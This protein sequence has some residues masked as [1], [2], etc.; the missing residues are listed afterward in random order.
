MMN[1]TTFAPA[2]TIRWMKKCPTGYATRTTIITDGTLLN[3][4]YTVEG[5]ITYVKGLRGGQVLEVR[6]TVL[7]DR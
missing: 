4:L 3:G 7:T 1:P 6:P 2:T 5:F